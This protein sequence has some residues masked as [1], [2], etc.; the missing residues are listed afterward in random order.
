MG[1]LL[2]GLCVGGVLFSLITGNVNALSEAA[3][4]SA[5]DA[6]ELWM[7]VAA[8]MMFW[9]GLMRVAD[10]AGIVDK[11]CRAVTPVLSLLMKDKAVGKNSPA[12]R[13]ASLNVTSNLLGLGNAA[14][15]FGIEAMKQLSRSGCS[16][17][18]M[19][20]FVLL[21]TSSIQLIPMNIIMLRSKS[22]SASP[23]D[24]IL[25]VLVNSLAAL[26]CGLLMITLLYGGKRDETVRF[27]RAGA[28]SF[29]A[30]RSGLPEG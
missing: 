26:C 23:S 1:V 18:T 11:V 4:H 2:A 12:M 20:V 21:N 10:K 19:A 25:P 29:C 7:A 6:G 24:C 8:G 15:P 16:R 30:G 9:N 17:R 28:D 13:A 5:V 3:A 22:G 27:G 14:M